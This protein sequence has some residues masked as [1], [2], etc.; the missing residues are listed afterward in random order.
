MLVVL[1]LEVVQLAAVT[2]LA[3]GVGMLNWHWHINYHGSCD[4]PLI[5]SQSYSPPG[6]ISYGIVQSF[7]NVYKMDIFFMGICLRL[8]ALPLIG[9][10]FF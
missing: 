10:Q 9:C 6:N 1:A 5:S 4:A 7:G 3:K 8:L 2:T